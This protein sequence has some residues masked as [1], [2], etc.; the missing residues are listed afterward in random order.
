MEI[1][2]VKQEWDQR[3]ISTLANLA[4]LQEPGAPAQRFRMVT[5]NRFSMNG[6]DVRIENETNRALLFGTGS[7]VIPNIGVQD[8][9]EILSEIVKNGA[10]PI[11][12][13]RPQKVKD[14]LIGEATRL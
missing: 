1:F 3:V 10:V 12:D 5:D 8:V 2:D 11:E 13:C 9:L 4:P 6:F 14:Y 7:S